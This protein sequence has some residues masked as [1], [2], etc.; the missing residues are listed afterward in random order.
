[1]KERKELKMT[2]VSAL[3]R[4]V[5]FMPFTNRVHWRKKHVSVKLWLVLVS[6]C[7][8]NKT[9]YHGLN[10][11]KHQSLLFYSSEKTEVGNESHWANTKVSSAPCSF[12]E[13]IGSNLFLCLF[14][15]LEVTSIPCLVVLSTFFKANTGQ[16]NLFHVAL[17][18]V[19]SPMPLSSHLRA[20]LITLDSP[21]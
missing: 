16:F 1:M 15:L 5:M 19:L 4:W 11:L 14:Q 2:H 7:C 3:N 10:D 6:C 8:S 17:S 18:L 20:H 12:L 9:I 21:R 13:A